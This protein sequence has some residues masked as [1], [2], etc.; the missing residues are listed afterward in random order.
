[1]LDVL[2][3]LGADKWS[4]PTVPEGRPVHDVA[5]HILGSKLRRLSRDRDGH[6][7][8]TES[9]GEWV[10]ACRGLSP[11]VL[12]ALLV[13]CSTQLV[14]LWKRLD[15]DE[16]DDPSGLPGWLASAREYTEFWVHQQRIR[17][18]VGVAPLDEPEFL[19]PVVDTFLRTLPHTLRESTAPK[20]KRVSYIVS[21]AAGGTWTA[22]RDADG[23]MLDQRPPPRAPFASVTTDPDTFWRLSTRTVR[24]E[25]VRD[26]ITTTGD[27]ELCT[28]M[29][30]VGGGTWPRPR[31]SPSPHPAP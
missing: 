13:D 30:G 29:L 1:L 2:G 21:G 4:T 14:D 19:A 6:H 28:A 3:E 10:S 27:A 17:E 15:P 7:V 8:D 18:A 9:P 23:W 5:A 16:V 31:K 12:F 11:E 20:G 25:D 24:L 26:R 22:V